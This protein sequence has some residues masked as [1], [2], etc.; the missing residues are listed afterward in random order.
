M[1]KMTIDDDELVVRLARWEKVAT[2][3]A[4]IRV[5][6]AAVD[7]VAV[8]PDAWR[9]LRGVRESGVLIPGA[10]WLGVWQHAGGRDFAAIRPKRH[11]VVSVDLHRP[12]PF[13]RISATCEDPQQ[14][15][16][17]LRKAVSRAMA[18]GTESC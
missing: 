2:G 3:Q 16:A 6:L 5:P 1:T 12:S 4:D 10:L 7:K 13:A 9:A 15:A 17:A 14:T 8:Q 18:A 11:G